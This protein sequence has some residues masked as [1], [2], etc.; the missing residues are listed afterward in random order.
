M[1]VIQA[2]KARSARLGWH[3]W[4]YWFHYAFAGAMITGLSQGGLAVVG[5]MLAVTFLAIPIGL[6]QVFIERR[7]F[8]HTA[9]TQ[10]QPGDVI[11]DPRT[12]QPVI[13]RET[14]EPYRVP[15]AAMSPFGSTVLVNPATGALMVGGMAGID[16]LGNP[17]GTNLASE[18]TGGDAFD[19]SGSFDGSCTDYSSQVD[20]FS[21]HDASDSFDPGSSGSGF[22]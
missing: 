15:D 22:D 9:P 14:G 19:H 1:A 8:P 20:Y 18:A 3:L 12:Q 11:R 21:G 13:N 10:P 5:W 17:F 4:G 16:V 2:L 7:L 6:L